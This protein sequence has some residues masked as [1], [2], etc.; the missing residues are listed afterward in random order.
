MPNQPCFIASLG[1][2]KSQFI[3]D[4]NNTH[5]ARPRRTSHDAHS[6]RTDGHGYNPS[7]FTIDGDQKK[8][9]VSAASSVVLMSFKRGRTENECERDFD[10]VNDPALKKRSMIMSIRLEIM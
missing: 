1:S 9:G 4:S 8:Q 6:T 5:I 10:I 3:L 2:C 7:R